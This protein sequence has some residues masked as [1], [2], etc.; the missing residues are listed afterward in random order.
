MQFQRSASHGIQALASYTWSH[1]IDFGSNNAALQL[2]RG[3]SDF[4][5]RSNLQGGITWDLPNEYS[6]AVLKTVLAGWALDG[7]LMNRT[8]F[9]ITLRGNLLT[10]T[11][12][13]SSY[14]G[15][16][17]VVANQP[18]YLYGSQYPGGRAVN[19]AAFQLPTIGGA[20]NA[21]RNFLR[22]FGATQVNLAVH[23]T[24][25]LGKG[26]TLQFRAE[27]FNLLNHP[28][29]GLVDATLSNATFGQATQT[30]NQS[31]ATM[32]AQYQQGGPRSLQFALKIQF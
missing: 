5:V 6:K 18:I 24:F 2:T 17:N 4:D 13:G 16:V 27:A 31:L 9:P 19:R 30:L 28:A 22:G 3:N 10:N 7:R 15:N 32:S 11:A 26:A 12:T 23:R 21:P 8:A 29:F 20:G 14:Y 25:G 1:S